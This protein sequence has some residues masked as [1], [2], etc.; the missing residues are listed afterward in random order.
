M[1]LFSYR[2]CQKRQSAGGRMDFAIETDVDGKQSML[3]SSQCV[4]VHLKDMNTYLQHLHIY[5]KASMCVLVLVCFCVIV[6]VGV[7]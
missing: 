7:F 5:A 6:C 4:N 3:V 1:Q 2:G